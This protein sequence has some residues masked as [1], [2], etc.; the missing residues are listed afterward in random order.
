[1]N[2]KEAKQTIRDYFR[3][4]YSD[5]QLAEFLDYTRAGKLRFMSCCCVA[6]F[7][8]RTKEMAPLELDESMNE[9]AKGLHILGLPNPRLNRVSDAFS[10]LGHPAVRETD[11]DALRRRILIPM[12]LAEIRRR[13]VCVPEQQKE[14]MRQP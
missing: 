9:H 4:A 1:M 6:G 2:F 3:T 11:R 5:D 14:T 13:A 10:L 12:I 8:T 7:V